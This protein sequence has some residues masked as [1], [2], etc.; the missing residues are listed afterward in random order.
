MPESRVE[1]DKVEPIS[2]RLEAEDLFDTFVISSKKL[3]V[4]GSGTTPLG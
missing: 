4:F 1:N 3:L 2:L